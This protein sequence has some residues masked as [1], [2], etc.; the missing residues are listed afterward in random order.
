[1]AVK[2]LAGI[3]IND[4]GLLVA[5][6]G[7]NVLRVW[8]PATQKRLFVTSLLPVEVGRALTPQR[9]RVVPP[10]AME[11]DARLLVQFGPANPEEAD[12]VAPQVTSLLDQ[13]KSSSMC[14]SS[15]GH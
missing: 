2:D 3:Q 6:Y 1:M 9:V 10:E 12:V 14:N 4:H 5:V 13:L 7:D 15:D 8:E 11:T